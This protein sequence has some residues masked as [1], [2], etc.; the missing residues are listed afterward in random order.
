MISTRVKLTAAFIVGLVAVTITLFLAASK[1]RNSV[2]VTATSPTMNAAVSLR[3]VE[4]MSYPAFGAAL[5][6]RIT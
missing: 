2:T 5:S 3:R 1:A 6:S 4:I